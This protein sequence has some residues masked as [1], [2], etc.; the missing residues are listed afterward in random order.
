MIQ[1]PELLDRL[2]ILFREQA[3]KEYL[4]KKIEEERIGKANNSE[5]KENEQKVY[6]M[7]LEDNAMK[8]DSECIRRRQMFFDKIKHF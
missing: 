5:D 2:E 7:A 6:N 8:Y 1:D 3:Y 4:E